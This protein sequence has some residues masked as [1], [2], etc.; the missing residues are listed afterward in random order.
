MNNIYK[1]VFND[2]TFSKSNIMCDK[3][4]FF[5]LAQI[6]TH[7]SL[8]VLTKYWSWGNSLHSNPVKLG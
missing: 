2:S 6:G 3:G 8:N 1:Y 5:G 7:M 4:I